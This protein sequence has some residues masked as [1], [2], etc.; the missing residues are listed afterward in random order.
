MECDCPAGTLRTFGASENVSEL[1]YCFFS[2]SH[3]QPN[4]AVLGI[5]KNQF[6]VRQT[7]SRS[8]KRCL[9]SNVQQLF[10]VVAW[11]KVCFPAFPVT[12]RFSIPILSFRVGRHDGDVSMVIQSPSS[13]QIQNRNNM[14]MV[15][16]NLHR[17]F[18]SRFIYLVHLSSYL[19]VRLFIECSNCEPILLVLVLI[20]DCRLGEN[21]HDVQALL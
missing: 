15:I 3:I 9:L 1:V 5:R 17:Y 12:H 20:L 10:V 21:G 11:N 2:Y 16:Q 7:D 8:A 18:P 13:C 19:L 6:K 4:A 14:S